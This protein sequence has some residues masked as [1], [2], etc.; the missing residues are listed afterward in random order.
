MVENIEFGF[1]FG[2]GLGLG[3]G[4]EKCQFSHSGYVLAGGRPVR[5]ISFVVVWHR[6]ESD[7]K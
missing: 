5:S 4:F 6:F 2:L 3:L 1:G 7:W